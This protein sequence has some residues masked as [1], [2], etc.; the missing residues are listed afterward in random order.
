MDGGVRLSASRQAYSLG[1]LWVLND[2]FGGLL[3]GL[4]QIA[5]G[6]GSTQLRIRA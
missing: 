3:R 5:L 4:L 1:W 2:Y 6:H